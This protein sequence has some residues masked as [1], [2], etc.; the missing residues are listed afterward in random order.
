MGSGYNGC[1]WDERTCALV[2]Y[3][4]YLDALKWAREKGCPW[5]KD[6]CIRYARK[7]PSILKWIV[8]IHFTLALC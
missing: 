5:D 7:H 4:G 6:A 8:S 1:P 2:A 3:N